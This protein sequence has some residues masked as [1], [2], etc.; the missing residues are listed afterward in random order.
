M[1]TTFSAV[2]PN[3]PYAATNKQAPAN[4]TW[5]KMQSTTNTGNLAGSSYSMTPSA[6]IVPFNRSGGFP[7]GRVQPRYRMGNPRR[8]ANNGSAPL[9]HPQP[10]RPPLNLKLSTGP[11]SSIPGVA[12]N[13]PSTFL[14]GGN[15]P[16]PMMAQQPVSS[17]APEPS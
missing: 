5:L 8:P 3:Q 11:T 6:P 14:A 7:A 16:Q 2:A 13:G 15:V 1:P 4:N 17:E 12:T 10:C 9:H